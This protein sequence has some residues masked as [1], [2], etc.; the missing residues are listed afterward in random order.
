MPHLQLI[1]V[2]EEHDASYK[3]T[4]PAPRYNARDCAVVMARLLGVPHAAGQRH[5]LARDVAQR[6][7]R[8]YGSRSWSV[9]APRAR[10]DLSSRIR[11]VR[12]GGE[13]TPTSTS[14]L[15][16]MEGDARRGEQV[17]LFQNR[18]GF[19]PYVECRRV[20]LDGPLSAL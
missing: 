19:A 15:D 7:G 9:T 13:R 14:V 5:P 12:R 8:K 6:R 17:M 3:Q 11:C 20:R 2:D 10:P 4:D 1:V 18:R 16:R